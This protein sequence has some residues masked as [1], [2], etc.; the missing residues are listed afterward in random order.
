MALTDAGLTVQTYQEVLSSIIVQEQE[1]VNPS[2]SVSD[3]TSLGQTNKVMATQIALVNEL[4]QDIYDQRSI[5]NAEG[6]ALDDNVSWLGLTRQSATATAGEQYF[7]GNDGTIISQGSYVQ[8]DSTLSNYTVDIPVQISRDACRACTIGVLTVDDSSYNYQVS[9]KGIFATYQSQS[10]DT[11]AEII[12]GLVSEINLTTDGDYAATDNGD[13]TLTVSLTNTVTPEDVAVTI[14]LNLKMES[15]TSAGNITGVETG[16]LPATANSVTTILSPTNGWTSTYNPNALILGRSE[17]TDAE[18]RDRAIN[19][20]SSTGKAT[21][22]S[23]RAA[24]LAVDGV[25]SAAVNER[26]VSEFS[27]DFIITPTPSDSTLYTVEIN[28]ESYS[29]TSGVSATAETISTGMV[30]VINTNLGNVGYS[31]VDNSDG[32]YTISPRMVYTLSLVD[33]T[34]NQEIE[35]GQPAGSIQVVVAGGLDDDIAQVV[36]DTKPAG[37]EVWAVNGGTFNQGTATDEYNETHVID[38]NRPTSIT[39]TVTVTYKVYDDSV[40]PV[41][42]EDAYDA[43][44][45]ALVDFG[46]ALGAGEDIK[47]SE[48]EG[49]VYGAVGGI[50]TV[51]IDMTSVNGSASSS[52]PEQEITINPD[53]EAFFDYDLITVTNQT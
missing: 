42:D 53:E 30:A 6:K 27:G 18:L 26:F 25:S 31:A 33:V 13:N 32:T 19:F 29:Y 41:D 45:N 50:Y 39:M 3:E 46:N 43:I 47:P 21:V 40:Y 48:F 16:A 10:G 9:V 36:W 22:D 49:T 34:G 44:K 11:E 2:I 7:V 12:S 51:Q 35:N 24:L 15:V 38:F 20:R 37:V 17:E 23:I 8:N 52:L 5:Y 1:D 4:L 28:G 14:D